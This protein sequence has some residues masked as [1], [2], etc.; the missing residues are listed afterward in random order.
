MP[1]FALRRR[2]LLRECLSNLDLCRILT[3]WPSSTEEKTFGAFEE[4][5]A[6]RA[7]AV[8]IRAKEKRAGRQLIRDQ[9]KFEEEDADSDT[10]SD[11]TSGGSV[12]TGVSSGKGSVLEK[13]IDDGG[14]SEK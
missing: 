4:E 2:R 14:D 10:D 12:S 3:E 11:S 8:S 7:M 9:K 13:A 6:L 1:R 5:A